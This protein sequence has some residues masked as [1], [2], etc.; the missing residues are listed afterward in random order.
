METKL[1]KQTDAAARGLLRNQ[2]VLNRTAQEA[3]QEAEGILETARQQA[4][5]IAAQAEKRRDETLEAGR[6]LGYREGLAQWNAA[7]ERIQRAAE[8]NS[9]AAEQQIIRLSMRV[10]EKIIGEQVRLE[11]N[12]IVSIVC[13]ALKSARRDRRLLLQVHPGQ[14][15]HVRQRLDA[16]RAACGDDREYR[17]LG[18]PKIESGGC[19]I[20]SEIGT[21][22]ARIDVQL[23]VLED[24]LLRP[25]R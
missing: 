2:R 23:Q 21:I 22:D 6:A 12:T 7:L 24:L 16:I 20:E 1:I 13:E 14:V 5:A 10:A 9:K 25:S 11:P 3:Y 17:V 8:T 18:N 4:E 15:E 19:I